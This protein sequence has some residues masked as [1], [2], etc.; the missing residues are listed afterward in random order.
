LLESL[1]LGKRASNVASIFVHIAHDP[2]REHVR[3][4]FW[5]ERA[6]TAVGQRCVVANP[7]IRA[8]MP[9]GSFCEA[10]IRSRACLLRVI[11]DSRPPKRG[12]A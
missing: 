10:A 4:A 3:T 7:M 9:G 11:L 12:P 1:G 6:R 2:P 5:L 8:D